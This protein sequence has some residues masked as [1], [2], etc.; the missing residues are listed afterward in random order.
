MSKSDNREMNMCLF[1]ERMI[2]MFL[3]MNG[4]SLD[5]KIIW[6]FDTNESFPDADAFKKTCLLYQI[7]EITLS[8]VH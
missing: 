8:C 1:L 3:W 4:L 2:K 6:E 5:Y 7:P